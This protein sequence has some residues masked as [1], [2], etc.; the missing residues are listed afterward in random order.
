MGPVGARTHE[1]GGGSDAQ[2]IVTSSRDLSRTLT[3]QSWGPKAL[4]HAVRTAFLTRGESPHSL[5]H[6][7]AST[8]LA[9][10]VPLTYVQRALNHSDPKLTSSLYGSHAPN[11]NVEAVDSLDDLVGLMGVVVGAITFVS[12][13]PPLWDRGRHFY[14]GETGHLHLGPT[15]QRLRF[16]RYVTVRRLIPLRAWPPENRR[17]RE[18]PVQF[19]RC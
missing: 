14:F 8:L 1:P 17:E 10:G 9:R 4:R 19:H 3:G 12:A 7:F 16:G 13:I 5:R 15:A 6:G 11:R 2:H 18:T